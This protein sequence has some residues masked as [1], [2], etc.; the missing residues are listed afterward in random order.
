MPRENFYLYSISMLTLMSK[1]QNWWHWTQWLQIEN[2]DKNE[3][4]IT[5]YNQWFCLH[6]GHILSG[7]ILDQSFSWFTA[8]VLILGTQDHIIFSNWVTHTILVCG[9]Y[10]AGID[11]ATVDSTVNRALLP[12]CRQACFTVDSDKKKYWKKHWGKTNFVNL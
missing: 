5:G 11:S 7:I 9:N 10:R 1:V 6:C 8:L 2:R 12:D 4:K 3:I